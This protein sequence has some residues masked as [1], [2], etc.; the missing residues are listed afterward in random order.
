MTNKESK[1]IKIRDKN[2]YDMIT[3]GVFKSKVILNKKKSPKKTKIDL[4]IEK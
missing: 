4:D 1:R 2:I 3:K